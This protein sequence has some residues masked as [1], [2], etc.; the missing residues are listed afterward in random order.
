MLKLK[1]IVII[2]TII[3]LNT[4]LPTVT[5]EVIQQVLVKVNGEIIT[6]LG[7][8][9][10]QVAILRQRPEI[11]SGTATDEQLRNALTE[12]TPGLI[13]NV[14]N[15]LLLVHRAKELGYSL[16]DEQ[17]Q[18]ILDNI[19]KENQLNSEEDFQNA[20]RQEGLS[21]SG[22]RKQI[23]SQMLINR[24]EQIEIVDKISVTDEEAQAYYQKNKTQFSTPSEVTLR[25]IL[26]ET[27]SSPTGINVAENEDALARAEAI[28]L[29][30]LSDEPFALLA[31]QISDAPSK[32]NGG[33]IGPL[34]VTVLSPQLLKIIDGLIPGDV[35]QVIQVD[36]GYQIL[37]L[38]S[39]TEE[40]ISPLEDIRPE[41]ADRIASEK[42]RVSREKYVE[43]LRQQ[44]II[45][46]RNDDLKKFYE[47]A[48]V[49]L[50]VETQKLE[51]PGQVQQ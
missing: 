43:T 13:L 36:L 19:R 12:I 15:E 48:L 46:W 16:P 3:L 1:T 50:R 51:E 29:R 11:A 33:L 31:G 32:A 40:V 27:P 5:A 39:R 45:T 44:A 35:S 49:T 23:E 34:S 25:E 14:V 2:V 42:I 28:R 47:Q 8:E 7:F 41:I 24:I 17:F 26:I 30:L 20:L 10:R 22:V 37:K 38:E 6:K 21:L 4:L 9:Q 18:T